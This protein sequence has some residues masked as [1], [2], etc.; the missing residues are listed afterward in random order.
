MKKTN[1]I[2]MVILILLIALVVYFFIGGKLYANVSTITAQASDYPDAF[3]S[4]RNVLTS[5]SA[6]QQFSGDI[7]SS[8][9]GWTL[10]DTTITL[11]N[12]GLFAAEWVDVSVE[13]APGDLAVYSLTGE[14]TDVGPQ[15][16][17]RINLKLITTAPESTQHTITLTY[18]V[19][20]MQRTLTVAG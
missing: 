16:S 10:M 17:T 6:P 4:I 13:P 12:R 19:Y 1:V 7:P 11:S 2:L 15:S 3:A 20:G 8:A 18:Y 5:G 9:D 14:G